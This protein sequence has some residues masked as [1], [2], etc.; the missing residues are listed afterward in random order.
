[1]AKKSIATSAELGELHGV[2]AT[3][4]IDEIK[5]YTTAK[6]PIPAA[7]L[8][9]ALKMLADNG[10]SV[11]PETP[12]GQTMEDLKDAFAKEALS[13]PFDPAQTH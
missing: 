9:Q 8:G 7:L 1:M 5:R 13:F 4:L 12:G 3:A 11:D 10:I 2:V 6:E